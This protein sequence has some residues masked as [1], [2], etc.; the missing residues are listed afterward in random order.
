MKSMICALETA[1]AR[2]AAGLLSAGLITTGLRAAVAASCIVAAVPEPARAQSGA[3]VPDQNLDQTQDPVSDQV[4]A[5]D[6]AAAGPLAPAEILA[7]VRQEGFFPVGRPAQ[8]GP[9]YFLHAV[10]Q[11]DIDVML[12]V[13]AATGRLLRVA[14]AAA[15]FGSPGASGW[16]SIWRD[17]PSAPDTPAS[18]DDAV[19]H[20]AVLRHFLHPPA[21]APPAAPLE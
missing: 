15:R 9:V 8:R 13:D 10:D 18:P 16:R 3:A 2:P 12:T 1:L 4:P 5:L 6:A 11:D 7:G 19:P 14:G 17:H 20:H 21:G